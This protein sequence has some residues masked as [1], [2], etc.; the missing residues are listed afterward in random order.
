MLRAD[1]KIAGSFGDER[2]LARMTKDGRLTIPISTL[3]LLQE[4]EEGEPR[5]LRPRSHR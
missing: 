1:V 3:K 4:D 5:R 2:F